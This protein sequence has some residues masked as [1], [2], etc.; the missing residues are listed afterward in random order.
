M[1]SEDET[2][3]TVNGIH[4]EP[5]VPMKKWRVQYEGEMMM[6]NEGSITTVH[7]VKLDAVYTSD[8]DYF[9]FDSDMEPWTVARAMAREP[10]SKEYFQ[11]LKDAHQ[12]HYEQF[13]DVSGILTIDGSKRDILVNLLNTRLG[14]QC[15]TPV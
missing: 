13:G 11:G 14:L 10:W 12:S 1:Q 8:L 4:L 6:K 3:W 7:R 2:G 9:D 5:L 15:Q